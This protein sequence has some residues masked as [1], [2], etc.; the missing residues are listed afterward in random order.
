MK[1]GIPAW[2]AVAVV[3]N[4]PR[5]VLA[6]SRGF[7]TRDPGFPGG[8][9]EPGDDTPAKT[10]ARELFEETGITALELKCIDEWVGER[11]QPVYVFYVPRWRGSRLRTSDEGKPFWTSPETLLKRTA[12][13]RMEAARVFE[14]LERLTEAAKEA[15]AI[16]EV[17][18]G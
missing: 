10:A 11:G 5:N 2:S 17:L 16:S 14:S 15:A 9:S 8:D 12:F 4:G 7:K 3:F 1:D 18:K 13:Y 6:V